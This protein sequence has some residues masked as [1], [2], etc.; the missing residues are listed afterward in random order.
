MLRTAYRA[1]SIIG[2]AMPLWLTIFLVKVMDEP[3]S[4]VWPSVASAC[5]VSFP[6]LFVAAAE[7]LWRVLIERF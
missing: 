2:A 1:V 3:M 6:F 4:L 7:L 5:I